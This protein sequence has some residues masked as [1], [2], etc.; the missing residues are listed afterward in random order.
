MRKKLKTYGFQFFSKT[1][2]KATDIQDLKIST[3]HHKISRFSG[4]GL[5]QRLSA[6]ASSNIRQTITQ[7]HC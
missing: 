2:L 7:S 1:L 6:K 5:L 4:G 3:L